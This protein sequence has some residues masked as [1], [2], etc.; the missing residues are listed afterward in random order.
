MTNWIM[1]GARSQPVVLALEDIQWAD[2]TTLDLLSGIAERGALAPLFVVITARPE[3][4]PP[5]GTRSHHSTISLV[6][7][8][9]GYSADATANALL[10]TFEQEA[11]HFLDEQRHAAAALGYVIDDF[12]R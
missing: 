10:P 4:R 7:R 5:W 11:R 9:S 6:P 12:L 3:F 8:R 1:A 2:P